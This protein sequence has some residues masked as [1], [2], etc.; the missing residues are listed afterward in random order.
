MLI[1]ITK[2]KTSRSKTVLLKDVKFYF[3][4]CGEV[5]GIVVGKGKPS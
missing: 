4:R 2:G 3:T 5:E 1:Q